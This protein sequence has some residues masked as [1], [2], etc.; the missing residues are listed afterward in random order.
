[1]R[2]DLCVCVCGLVSV[3]EM[4]GGDSQVWVVCGRAVAASMAAL[5]EPTFSLR[6][7][8]SDAD[9]LL[10]QTDSSQRHNSHSVHVLDLVSHPPLF[11]RRA[12]QM[13]YRGS[14][15]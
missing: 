5:T 1:V 3:P 8:F 7:S 10:V 2:V 11:S 14:P 6:R 12:G 15:R 4:V 9:R 13:F